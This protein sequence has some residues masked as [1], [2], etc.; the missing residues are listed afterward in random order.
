[1]DITLRNCGL[2]SFVIVGVALEIGIEPTVKHST[3][4]GYIHIAVTDACGDRD[5]AAMERTQV[6]A[7]IHRRCPTHRQR[8][9]LRV[10]SVV[11]ALAVFLFRPLFRI[12]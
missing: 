3:D 5:A 6:Q 12:Q 7:A 2:N 1:L 4:L 9:N 8:G 10:I 11:T